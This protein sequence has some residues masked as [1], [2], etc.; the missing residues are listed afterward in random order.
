MIDPGNMVKAND[1]A[2]TTIVSMDPMYAYFDVDERTTLQIRRLVEAGKIRLARAGTP[3]STWA[4]PTRK[5]IRTRERSI[6]S[7]TRSM[8][9]TGTMR[10]RGVFPNRRHILTPGLFVRIQ[11]PIG[12]PHPSLLVSERALGSDQGRS[13]FTSSMTTTK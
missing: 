2:L 1:T 12:Q 13:S 5:V 6:S 7:T 3:R 4:W 9:A 8:P 11:M 10:F